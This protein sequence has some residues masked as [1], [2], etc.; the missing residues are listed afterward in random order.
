MRAGIVSRHH[1]DAAPSTCASTDKQARREAASA[2]GSSHRG[3][4]TLPGSGANAV[5]TPHSATTITAAGNIT[6]GRDFCAA[7]CSKCTTGK[8]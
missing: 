1:R 6:I 8:A 5:N 3:A 4:F 2:A 7:V